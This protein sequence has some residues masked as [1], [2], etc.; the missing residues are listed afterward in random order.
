MTKSKVIVVPVS[1]INF[2]VEKGIWID[3]MSME[4]HTDNQE[5]TELLPGIIGNDYSLHKLAK[6]IQKIAKSD[7]AV[8]LKGETGS[9]KEL[10]ANAIHQLSGNTG[11]FVAVNCA[12][13]PE[14]LFESLLFGHEKGSFTGAEKR[15][16]G[17]FAQANGGT[18]FLDEIAEL[19]L[20]HQSKLLRVLES[21][22]FRRIGSHEE[23]EFTGRIITATHADMVKMVENRQFRQDLYY[24][25]NIFEL[26]IPSLEQ[27]RDDIPLLINFFA[28]Q[29]GD[30]HF[31]PCA[32]EH[33]KNASWPGN[34]RQLKNTI[35]KLAVLSDNNVI[36]AECITS[37]LDHQ[38]ESNIT[39][40]LAREIISM[41]G[42]NK[43][44][45]ICDA[46]VEE[47]IAISGGNKTKAA[48]LLGVH[49]KVV[50]RRFF[51]MQSHQSSGLYYIGNKQEEGQYGPK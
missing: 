42:D 51:Q 43:I 41:Q 16:N 8:F 48:M 11:E 39:S 14:N 19:P 10:F 4:N 12:A 1:N 5:I 18:L 45:T 15:Q 40:R 47:A 26:H 22:H 33:L 7:H 24:R 17:Y 34:I 36:S 20:I 13:I 3:T 31:S 2:P 29:N 30:V 25:L 49:R 38:P 21:R 6:Q 35:D 32:I 50:E 23:I 28:E 46:L 37:L 27:R 9:G 44:K